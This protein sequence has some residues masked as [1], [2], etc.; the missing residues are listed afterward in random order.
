MRREGEIRVGGRRLAYLEAGSQGPVLLLAHGFPLD[1]WM[2]RHQIDHFE[3]TCRV[4]AIDLRGFGRSE[5]GDEE[6]SMEQMA[7]DCAAVAEATVGGESVTFVGLSMGGYV[8]WQFWKRHRQRLSRLVLCDTRAKGDTEDVARGRR[9]M[10][11]D[12]LARGPIVAVESLLPRLLSPGNHLQQ[13]ELVESLRGTMMSTSASAIAAAQRGLAS[14]RDVVSWLGEI[15]VP[16]L[17]ICGAED[18]ISRPEEMQEIAE[19][20]PRARFV[21]IPGAGHM[22]PLENPDA[23]NRS[24]DAFLFSA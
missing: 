12:V 16:A 7:D 17:L 15:D 14:R 2:W 21:C 10:A 20:M 18:E 11:Y 4:L 13:P 3:K 9:R 8:A 24:I 5:P 23:V 22:A 1:R 6:A 19:R